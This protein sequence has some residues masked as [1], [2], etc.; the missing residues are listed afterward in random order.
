[1]KKLSKF[2]LEAKKLKD[3]EVDDS[4]FDAEANRQMV[5]DYIVAI[6]KNKRQW[7][8]STQGR[9]EVSHS[10]KKPHKQKGTGNARQ[11]RLSSP[12]YKGGGVVFGPRPK[13]DQHVRIN[14]KERRHVIE[15][16][17]GEKIREGKLIVLHDGEMKAPRTKTVVHFMKECSLDKR[18][19]FLVDSFG[20]DPEA[21][22]AKY[23]NLRKSV[24]NLPRVDFSCV[25]NVNGYQLMLAQHV[26]ITESGLKQYMEWMKNEQ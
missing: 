20:R 14:K 12:Q 2:N 3:A 13:F 6:R 24:R 23:V 18:T 9:S 17:I 19:L 4:L 26:V 8:A 10:T 22:E 1:M 7:S 16:L 11:G 25:T 21:S 15:Y 5:K